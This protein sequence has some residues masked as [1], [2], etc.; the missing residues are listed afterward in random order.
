TKMGTSN[1]TLKATWSAIATPK[2]TITFDANGGS[3]SESS[4]SVEEGAAYGTLPTPT[5]T[6]YTFNGWQTSGGTYVT[7]STKMGTSNV[8]LT[9][10]WTKNATPK[11]TITFDANGG[12]VS[13]TSRSV[14]EGAA[15]GTLPTPSRSGYTFNGWTSGGSSVSA[16]TKMG[17]S[18]VTLK[19][20]WTQNKHT[21]TFDANG[22][23]VSE[24]S[25]SV[26]E[27]AE[28]GTLPTPTRLGYTFD[29][30]QSEGTTVSASTKMGTSD[31]TLKASWTQNPTPKHTITFDANGGSVNPGSK[32]VE[33]GAAYGD[34][35]TPT[36][37][38]YTFNGWI[39]DGSAA[40][41]PVD[42]RTTMGT[43]DITIKAQWTRIPTKHTLSFNAGGIGNTSATGA[44]CNETSREVLEGDAYGTL[45]TP[46]APGYTF[47]YWEDFA[48]GRV[49]ADTKMGE[50]DVTLYANWTANTIT[51]TYNLNTGDSIGTNP[52]TI[53][54]GQNYNLSGTK[55]GHVL[56]GWYD[57]N[58]NKVTSTGSLTTD[59]A[60]TAE[61]D[62][63]SYTVI[64]NRYGLGQNG[65][66]NKNDFKDSLTLSIT[67]GNYTEVTQSY[68]IY[69][70]RKIT[71]GTFYDDV[72]YDASYNGQSITVDAPAY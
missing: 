17:T 19:A 54:V 14:E 28:Y 29:G 10:N 24:T 38:G 46:S 61:W 2:H 42:S 69:G 8:T 15:Y 70:G 59:T 41:I 47:N 6:G 23:S 53:T 34:L 65:D 51:I 44:S 50:F 64:I 18:D 58:G 66:I 55:K 35:P 68:I 40:A 37:N 13:E 5:R 11:H 1:V 39:Q 21:I 33:E 30:W 4:R 25:R 56:R 7:S 31:V 36:R 32:E 63:I 62:P 26:S 22:G 67:Y 52:T 57:S 60:L 71:A 72:F 3:V 49:N 12:S 45:P 48:T 9:A 27:G 43:S 20:S 16:S